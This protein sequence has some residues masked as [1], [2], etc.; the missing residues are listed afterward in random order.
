MN[1][2]H[3]TCVGEVHGPMEDTRAWIEQ[4]SKTLRPLLKERYPG[5]HFNQMKITSNADHL[6]TDL[7]NS[8][9]PDIIDVCF[10]VSGCPADL[11]RHRFV[12]PSWWSLIAEGRKTTMAAETEGFGRAYTLHRV[13]ADWYR[14]NHGE[15]V[16][17]LDRVMCFTLPQILAKLAR[18]ETQP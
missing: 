1:L 13:K 14:V 9:D 4:T 12:H 5:L 7:P 8:A 6:L 18:K 17:G 10:N 16:D 11:E 2:P 3:F 15:Y